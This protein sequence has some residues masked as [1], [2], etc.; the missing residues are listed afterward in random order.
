MHIDVEDLEVDATP[1]D[2]MLSYVSGEKGK[3][4][5][6]IALSCMP[7]GFCSC[8]I[9]INPTASMLEVFALVGLD[10][11]YIVFLTSLRAAGAHFGSS[12]LRLQYLH[13]SIAEYWQSSGGKGEFPD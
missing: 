3:V 7:W 4:G 10:L 12:L 11:T 13:R 8:I 2:L 5:A 6:V 1:E 9:A